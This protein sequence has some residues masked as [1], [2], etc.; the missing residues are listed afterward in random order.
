MV[1]VATSGH[2]WVLF[3]NKEDNRGMEEV[4]K[5]KGLSWVD[6]DRGHSTYHWD[7]DS[8]VNFN[9]NLNHNIIIKAVL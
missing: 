7:R 5:V 8:S 6:I 1:A 4:S 9:H 3:I 2:I